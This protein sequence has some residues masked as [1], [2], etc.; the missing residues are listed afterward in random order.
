MTVMAVIMGG[1]TSGVIFRATIRQT[2]NTLHMC[3]HKNVKN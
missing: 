3:K 1:D 2:E